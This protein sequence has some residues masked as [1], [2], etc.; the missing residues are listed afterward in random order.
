MEFG[1]FPLKRS[2]RRY[3]SDEFLPIDDRH[4][5]SENRTGKISDAYTTYKN[6]SLVTIKVKFSDNLLNAKEANNLPKGLPVGFIDDENLKN[7]QARS[8]ILPDYHASSTRIFHL[9]TPIFRQIG[10]W[11]NLSPSS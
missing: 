1:I 5:L 4:C 9:S 10:S 8:A 2:S 7:L 3:D 11:L 6:G